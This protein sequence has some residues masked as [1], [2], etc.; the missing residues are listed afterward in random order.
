M[1]SVPRRNECKDIHENCP[2]W[3]EAAE[4]KTN[5]AVKK[6]CPLSCGRCENTGNTAHNMKKETRDMGRVATTKSEN[7]SCKD[8]HENCSGWAVR[9]LFAIFRR[10]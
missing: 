3:V 1:K 10:F 6:Y 2:V 9:L 5:D 4:C 7:Q 8:D